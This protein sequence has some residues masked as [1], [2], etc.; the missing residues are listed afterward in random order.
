MIKREGKANDEKNYRILK[1]KPYRNFHWLTMI[2]D[3]PP[4]NEF[5]YDL[6]LTKSK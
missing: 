6:N 1:E 4:M 3:D 2:S 5:G